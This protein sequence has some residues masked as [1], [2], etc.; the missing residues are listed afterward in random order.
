L[1]REYR[2]NVAFFDLEVHD[3]LLARVYGTME[4][5]HLLPLIF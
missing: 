1:G 4:L 3:P 5:L 2:I